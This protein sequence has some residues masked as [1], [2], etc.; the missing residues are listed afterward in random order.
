MPVNKMRQN[1]SQMQDVWAYDK[2][3]KAQL[4]LLLNNG[5]VMS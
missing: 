5:S 1:K 4:K 2:P 3:L